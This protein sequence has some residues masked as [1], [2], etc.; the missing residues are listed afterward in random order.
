[1]ASRYA[2]PTAPAAA[3]AAS[4]KTIKIKADYVPKAKRGSSS[5]TSSS[6]KGRG[7]TQLC[8]RCKR[9]IPVAEMEEHVRIELLDPQWRQQRDRAAENLASSNLLTGGVIAENL[10]R[11]STFRSD[12]FD[13]DEGARVEKMRELNQK[14]KENEDKIWDGHT[15]TITAVQ[16][17][18]FTIGMQELLS[19]RSREEVE[20]DLIG[21][22]SKKVVTGEAAPVA[23]ATPATAA[24]TDV[25]SA[26]VSYGYPYAYSDQGSSTAGY[27]QTANG[28][29]SQRGA[30]QSSA[31]G[32]ETATPSTVSSYYGQAPGVS[33]TLP[34]VDSYPNPAAPSVPSVL[35]AVPPPQ[36]LTSVA[37]YPI[38]SLTS[39]KKHEPTLPGFIPEPHFLAMAKTPFSLSI[40][41]PQAFLDKVS[42]EKLP[43][44]FP[45][46]PPRRP[47][48]SSAT[49]TSGSDAGYGSVIV[50]PSISPSALVSDIKEKLSALTGMPASKQKMTLPERMRTARQVMKDSLTAAYY[51]L[52]ASDI[53]ELGSRERGGKK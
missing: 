23:V 3:A 32:A 10:K 28:F 11:I 27:Y 36:P 47:G 9:A 1:M 53:V 21:P 45:A 12:I 44:R 8:P 33:T 35:A 6:A 34:A 46:P 29:D 38:P 5:S 42:S 31:A 40:R 2:A 43:W 25:S 30:V 19:K 39:S 49:A 48:S 51:N 15:A 37:V 20:E 14:A 7:L 41:I 24:T 50:I 52:C 16:Q 22:Q 4:A 26:S 13:G 18:A 17:K